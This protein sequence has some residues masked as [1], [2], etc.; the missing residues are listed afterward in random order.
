MQNLYQ[1]IEET[2]SVIRKKIS[3]DYKIG[4][5]LGTGLGALVNEIEKEY[6][7]DYAELPYFPLSTV[8]SSW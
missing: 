7:F 6:E 4:I 2:V 3:E 8:I 1:S 5:I